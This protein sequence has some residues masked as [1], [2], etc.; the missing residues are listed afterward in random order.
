MFSDKSRMFLVKS[1]S[2]GLGSQCFGVKRRPRHANASVEVPSASAKVNVS[3]WN[4]VFLSKE[5]LNYNHF[6][7]KI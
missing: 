5:I 7:G 1:T 2:G 3:G 6:I 4:V